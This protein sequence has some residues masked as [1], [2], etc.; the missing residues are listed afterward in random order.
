MMA[1]MRPTGTPSAAN[2][3]TPHLTLI[4]LIQLISAPICGQMV[5]SRRANERRH[6]SSLSERL[7]WLSLAYSISLQS[8]CEIVTDSVMASYHCMMDPV[9]ASG[10]IMSAS[11]LEMYGVLDMKP[12]T[13]YLPRQPFYSAILH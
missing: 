4:P 12:G 1:V 8:T 5:T 9:Q 7:E 2:C 3:P 13:M 6:F 10:Y 11:D